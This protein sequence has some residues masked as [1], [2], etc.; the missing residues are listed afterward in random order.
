MDNQGF[1]QI[2]DVHSISDGTQEPVSTS[3]RVRLFI[4]QLL[5][6]R[7]VRML[8]KHL[9]DYKNF[10]AR[11]RDKDTKP[12]RE[13]IHTAEM[14]LSVGNIVRVRSVQE[15]KTTLN[16]MGQLKGCSFASEMA[17]YCG[18]SQRVLKVVERFIDERDLQPRKTKGIVL[19]DGIICQGTQTLGRCDRNCLYFW[20]EEWLEKIEA[21]AE[22]TGVILEQLAQ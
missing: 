20:R 1:C 12:P 15:I 14:K 18:T 21:P 13:V 16:H 6:P 10:I 5:G 3:K 9:N 2:K 7:K 22:S 11:L 19:L 4:R 17:Q 8:K